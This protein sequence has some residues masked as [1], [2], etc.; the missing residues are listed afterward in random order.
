MLVNRCCEGLLCAVDTDLQ[1][2]RLKSDIL[3]TTKNYTKRS[4]I[5]IHRVEPRYSDIG[6][7]DSSSVASDILWYQLIRHC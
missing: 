4:D 6:L 2:L 1:V 7:C 3:V 5:Y